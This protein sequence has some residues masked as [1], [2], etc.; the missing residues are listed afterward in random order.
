MP[1]AAE[2]TTTPVSPFTSPREP[3]ASVPPGAPPQPQTQPPP[4]K[5]VTLLCR[6]RVRVGFLLVVGVMTEGVLDKEA[7]RDLLQPG[8]WLALA[9]PLI[10]A[11][12]MIRLISLG[13]I[14]K[15]ESLACRGIYSRCRHPLYFGSLLLYTGL[16]II[17]N[18]QFEYWYLG[19]PYIFIF[20][21]AA[22]FNEERFLK[23]KFGA[24]FDEFKRSTPALLPIGRYQPG[25]FSWGRA[26]Q[27]GGIKL[28]TSV[29]GMVLAMQAMVI[30]FRKF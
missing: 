9:A 2:M 11:G 6:W 10:V 8:W 21:T 5:L 3:S 20:Y 15:N 25:E 26:M 27:K 19:I 22:V 23:G 12:A 28:I 17:L 29:V 1:I 14:R 18:D 16:G 13:T 24:Q 4:S 7:P 30:I